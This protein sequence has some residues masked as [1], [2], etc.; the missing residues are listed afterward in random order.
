LQIIE[1]LSPVAAWLDQ[2]RDDELYANSLEAQ[3]DKF[4]DASLT[5]SS[6][7]LKGVFE[8][9][10]FFDFAQEISE[11]QHESLLNMPIDKSLHETLQQ[12][13]NQS[14]SVREKLEADSTGSFEDFLS[15]YFSQ[16]EGET[17]AA[18]VKN[19][20]ADIS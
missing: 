14:L 17:A 6:R 20:M 15:Q 13:V 3:R 10:S 16:L 11:S 12:Q 19:P 8:S 4:N 18:A 7:V 5:P 2:T 9:G 1:A